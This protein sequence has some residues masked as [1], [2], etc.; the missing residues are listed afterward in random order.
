MRIGF[1]GAG[2]M[3]APMV[4]RLLKAGHDVQ[5][6]NRTLAKAEA[7]RADGARVATTLKE[8][9]TDVDLLIAVIENGAA[10]RAVLFAQELLAQLSPGQVVVDMS[11]IAPHEAVEINGRF[12]DMGM[13]Y[14]D[15]PISGGPDG[16][17]AGTLAIMAGGEAEAIEAARPALECMGRLTHV[18]PSGSGQTVKLLNQ[19]I[20]STAIA[21]VSEVMV[22]ASKLGLD[23]ALVRSA[24]AGG[25]AD[26]KILQIHGRRMTERD[27]VPGG[28]VRTFLKDL[29]NAATIIAAQ[30]LVLPV[31]DLARNYFAQLSTIGHGDDDIASVV[32]ITESRN[33]FHPP[34]PDAV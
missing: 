4:Q 5:I 10:V 25:F 17:E 11:S 12:R 27:F 8:V 2:V 22:L 19:T 33:G 16:A 23:P 9:A 34:G 21:A 18:G 29:N 7:L 31:A 28:H 32:L 20:S 24:L 3:G 13:S 1:I 30:G 14:V 15:A 6:W 26:S